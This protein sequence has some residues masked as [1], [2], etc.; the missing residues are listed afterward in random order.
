[1]KLSSDLL[2][3]LLSVWTGSLFFMLLP[4][5]DLGLSLSCSFEVEPEQTEGRRTFPESRPLTLC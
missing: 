5:G 1:M 4:P 3:L 2:N